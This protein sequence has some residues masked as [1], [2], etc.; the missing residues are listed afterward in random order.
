MK[1]KALIRISII[2][3]KEKIASES[4]KNDD[5][6]RIESVKNNDRNRY[7]AYFGVNECVVVE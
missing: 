1:V 3:F 2:T 7:T 4:K 5:D 6:F